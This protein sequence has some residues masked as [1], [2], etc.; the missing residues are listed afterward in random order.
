VVQLNL[1]RSIRIILEQL[2]SLTTTKPIPFEDSKVPRTVH[3][4]SQLS[5]SPRMNGSTSSL[6]ISSQSSGRSSDSDLPSTAGSIITSLRTSYPHSPISPVSP[7]Q[8]TPTSPFSAP[9]P[10]PMLPTEMPKLSDYHR[11]LR[12]RLLPVIHLESS[13]LRRLNPSGDDEATHL[14]GNW[15]SDGREL[16]VRSSVN[17]KEKAAR[18]RNRGLEM[19]DSLAEDDGDDFDNPEDPNHV[20]YACKDDMLAL[21]NDPVVRQV[22]RIGNVRLEEMP[23]L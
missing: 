17:W 4:L 1:V 2:S 20:I 3:P 7:T 9:L 23:G 15:S 8:R 12:M 5:S 16:F 22:L 19:R 18:L 11:T 6:A 14:S 21:W 13:L 10:P